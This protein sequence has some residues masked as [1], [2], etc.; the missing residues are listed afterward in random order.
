M[1]N[2]PTNDA[3]NN[4]F[5][6]RF[7]GI[8]RL[9]GAN[10]VPIIQNLHVCVVGLGGV[11]S[12]AVEALARTGVGRLT[13]ID[14]DTVALSN[15]NRQLPAMTDT[16]GLKKA[17]V[18][19]ERVG[20]INPDCGCEVIDDFITV[21]N[22]RDYLDPARHYGYVVDAI[23]SITFKAQ[24]IYH[25]KRNKIP[26][27]ATGGAGGL[28][29]PTLIHVKDLR[30]TYNDPLAAKVRSRLRSDFGFSKNPKRNFGIECVFSSQQQVYPKP[31]GSVSH[32]K[33]GIHGISLDCNM[34]YGSAAFVT[35]VF[36]QVAASR[37]INRTLQKA[38]RRKTSKV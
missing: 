34:G 6:Q 32:Q 30:Q 9:Y 38:A 20:Q 3:M 23:D 21:A 4:T 31:D 33:P 29:D 16:D 19:R 25:C 1:P 12:W 35:A 26:I 17:S 28:T 10:A 24:M 7:G 2:K 14:Y 22:L 15:I 11:G 27:I 13:L 5:E 8:R 36:G 37:V 18:L